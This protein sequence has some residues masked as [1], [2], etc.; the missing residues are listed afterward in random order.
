MN[1]KQFCSDILILSDPEKAKQMSS[2]MRNQFEFLGVPADRRREA[3]KKQFETAKDENEIDWEFV[4]ACWDQK[5]REF[6][7]AAIDYLTLM[8]HFLQEED[9]E[10]IEALILDKPWWDTVDNLNRPVGTLVMTYPQLED[11]MREWSLSEEIWLHRSAIIFQ[12]G[13]KKFT[14]AE[15]LYE[16]IQNNFDSKEFFINKAIGWALREFSK[17]DPDSVAGFLREY[18]HRLATVSYREATKILNKTN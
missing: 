3:S 5:F 11:K 13:F 15:L 7:Y 12:L 1:F 16:I 14:N 8:Q 10:K 17:T 2:Y 6:Q 9:L 18:K 4:E